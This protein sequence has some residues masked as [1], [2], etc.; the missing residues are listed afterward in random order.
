MA[1]VNKAVAARIIQCDG[2]YPGDEDT[3]V[4]RVVRYKRTISGVDQYG[5]VDEREA[6]S[7]PHELF[8][9]DET[10]HYIN[11]PVVIWRHKDWRI[12][13]HAVIDETEALDLF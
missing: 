1:S 3:L 6:R 4:V 10:T 7:N 9:Y 5:I 13:G 11:G 2:I 8:R 12:D